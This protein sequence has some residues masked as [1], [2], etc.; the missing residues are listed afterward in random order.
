MSVPFDTK[1]INWK[2]SQSDGS[3]ICSKCK[4]TVMV[5]ESIDTRIDGYPEDPT[6]FCTPCVTPVPNMRSK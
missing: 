6:V 5:G 3:A 1:A 2:R 4:R